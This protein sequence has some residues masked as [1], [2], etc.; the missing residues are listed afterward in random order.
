MMKIKILTGIAALLFS[1][2]IWT[3]AADDA[4][5]GDKKVTR[6]VSSFTE[7]ELSVAANLYLKQGSEH[8]LV[9]EGDEDELDVSIS[10]S[11]KVRYKGAPRVNA[12]ISGSGRAESY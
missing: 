7:I 8:R 4:T 10:G 6:E 11:G 3:Q 2:V 9:L 12:S 5:S 1:S